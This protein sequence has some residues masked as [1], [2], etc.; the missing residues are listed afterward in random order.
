[1]TRAKL[2]ANAGNFTRGLHVKRPHTQ[3]TCVTCSLPVKTGEFTRGYAASTSR[4]LHASYLQPHVILPEHNGYF[5]GN[6]TCGTHA[7]L[8][9]TSMLNGLRLQ[10]KNTCNLQAKT[11]D[12]QVKTPTN[13]GNNN[14]KR[15]EKYPHNR[16]QK[17]PQLHPKIPSIA[18]NL[19]S[20]FG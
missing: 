11:L 15:R 17:C 12:S 3:F 10:A 7:N 16:R 13:A 20:H 4:R 19:L 2:P 8:L 1:M 9:A 5:R 6:F 18:G 14:C